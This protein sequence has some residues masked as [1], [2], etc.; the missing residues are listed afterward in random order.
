MSIQTLAWVILLFEGYTSFQVITDLFL[1][2]LL[3]PL[4][5]QVL[6]FL[7]SEIFF[8]IV[9]SDLINLSTFLLHK[10]R[11]KMP[12]YWECLCFLSQ[13][14]SQL[15]AEQSVINLLFLLLYFFRTSKS[16]RS[17]IS[18][19]EKNSGQLNPSTCVCDKFLNKYNNSFK[20]CQY[21]FYLV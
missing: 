2:S 11:Y 7:F 16:Y 14:R 5:H 6:T 9:S 8:F 10:R 1:Y 12:S 3:L 4:L 15:Y 19:I 21:F 17:I 20:I 13:W 18:I